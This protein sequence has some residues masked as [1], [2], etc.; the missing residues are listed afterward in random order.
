[1]LQESGAVGRCGDVEVTVG[2]D[3]SIRQFKNRFWPQG[4]VADSPLLQ[5]EVTEKGEKVALELASIEIAPWHDLLITLRHPNGDDLSVG[6]C[7]NEG[8]DGMH[9]FVSSLLTN[10]PDPGMQTGLMMIVHSALQGLRVVADQ[11]LGQQEIKAEGTYRKKYPT[12]DWM[13][14]P[15]WFEEVEHPFTGSSFVDLQ[16]ADG[17]RGMLVTYD[18]TR[19]WFRDG[20]SV[21]CLLNMYDPWDEDYFEEITSSWFHFVPH[22]GMTNDQRYRLALEM[23]RGC[24]CTIVGESKRDIPARMSG[25]ST[26]QENV[27][28]IAFYREME[29]AGREVSPFAGEGMGYPYVLRLLELNGEETEAVVSVPGTVA[30]AVRSNLLGE[31]EGH[32]SVEEGGIRLALKPFEIATVYLDIEEGRKQVRDLDAHRNI[33]AQV[34]R[35]GEA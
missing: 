34:H 8:F 29:S 13:T 3:G 2:P 7:L 1:T 19:Q 11:P 27:A 32:A 16:S 23:N 14:S 5:F 22:G 15:Q 31:P 6:I 17:D 35:E 33:W 26:D 21:K 20:D 18:R 30:K 28:V 9:V 24:E 12:G 4:I 10:R 25:P